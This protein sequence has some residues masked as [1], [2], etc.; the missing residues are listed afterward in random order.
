MRSTVTLLAGALALAL[1]AGALAHGAA[2]GDHGA[3]HDAGRQGAAVSQGAS[4]T[5][6]PGSVH[7]HVPVVALIA[8]GTVVSVDTTTGSAVVQVT[9]ANHHGSGLVGTQVTID[10]SK[11][12]ISVADGNGDGLENLADVAVSDQVLLQGRIPLHSTLTGALSAT[13]L[14]DQTHPASSDTSSGTQATSTD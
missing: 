1:P 10:L 7:R 2:G 12:A 9:R 13:R 3:G 6:G 5:R 11:A 4:G 8:H 14:I